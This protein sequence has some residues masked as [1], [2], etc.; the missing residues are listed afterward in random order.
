MFSEWLH[1]I[2]SFRSDDEAYQSG[3]HHAAIELA[4]SPDYQHTVQLLLDTGCNDAFERGVADVLAEQG[5]AN[6]NTPTAPR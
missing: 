1:A 2:R 6:T 5:F 4:Y 3:R